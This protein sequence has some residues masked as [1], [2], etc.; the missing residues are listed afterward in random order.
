M[1]KTRSFISNSEIK[2]ARRLFLKIAFFVPLLLLVI[3]VNLKHDPAGLYR[4]KTDKQETFEYKIAQ[5]MIAGR[6]V[7]VARLIDDRL[8]QKYFIEGLTYAPDIVVLGSSRSLWLGENIFPDKKVIDHSLVDPELADYLGIFEGYAKKD[9]FPQ[10]VILILDPQLIGTPV[11]SERWLSIKEDIYSMLGRLGLPAQDLKE[12]LIP[13]AWLNIFS[14][15]YFQNA[16]KRSRDNHHHIIHHLNGE[17]SSEEFYL[18]DG[19]CLMRFLFR[20]KEQRSVRDVYFG[21]FEQAFKKRMRADKGS[22]R[23]LEDFIRYLSGH[24]IQVTLCLLP[25]HPQLY[26]SFIGPPN[27]RGALDIVG[28]EDYYHGLARKLNLEIIGSYDPA[29][30]GL[31]GKDFYDGIH[32][33]NEVLERILKEKGNQCSMS[34]I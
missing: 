2:D 22:E 5:A 1:G 24:H 8:L 17:I 10:R 21:P 18:K 30:C 9:Q 15:S 7:R 6:N 14:L 31:E 32:I 33:R 23:I 28:F 12:P 19:R 25:I 20:N 26:K 16:I 29:A 3:F 4:K 13:Q 27:S 34:G 11:M